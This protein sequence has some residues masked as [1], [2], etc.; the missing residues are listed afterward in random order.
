MWFCL[1]ERSRNEVYQFPQFSL[2]EP[3][4]VAAWALLYFCEHINAVLYN[5]PFGESVKVYFQCGRAVV[6]DSTAGARILGDYGSFVCWGS[7]STALQSTDC[8]T[9]FP[10][11]SAGPVQLQGFF[12]L[13]LK[14]SSGQIWGCWDGVLHVQVELPHVSAPAGEF[15]WI[16]PVSHIYLWWN[17]FDFIKCVVMA[18]DTLMGILSLCCMS[19]LFPVLFPIS[20]LVVYPKTRLSFS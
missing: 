17:F 13:I 14:N 5:C 19:Q 11:G 1:A 12:F 20:R 7:S 15:T 18:R 9:A 16:L 6:R 2:S 4:V 10:E 3:H 8:V